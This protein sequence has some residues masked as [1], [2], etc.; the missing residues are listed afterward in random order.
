MRLVVAGAGPL[1]ESVAKVAE[2]NGK[3]SFLGQ[4]GAEERDTLLREAA[5]VVIPST[6]P[7]AGSTLVFFEAR[8][9]SRGRSPTCSRTRRGWPDFGRPRSGA[10]TLPR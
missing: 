3:V 2:A 8:A 4:V 5:A 6:C 10:D 9:H 7:E 1:A